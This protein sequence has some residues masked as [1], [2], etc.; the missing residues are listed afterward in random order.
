VYLT[1]KW[2]RFLQ[3][4]ERQCHSFADCLFVDQQL[5]FTKYAVVASCCQREKCKT[6]LF[7]ISFGW[8]GVSSMIR[9]HGQNFSAIQL[10]LSLCVLNCFHTV[11]SETVG[12]NGDRDFARRALS[13][14]AYVHSFGSDTRLQLE[15]LL[16]W[17]LPGM[18]HL[19]SL[20]M[21]LELNAL[22]R[23][24][25]RSMAV[26]VS[27]YIMC[28]GTHFY[29]RSSS[30]HS[31]LFNVR[32]LNSYCHVTS[33]TLLDELLRSTHLMY[34]WSAVSMLPMR[35]F[36]H[37]VIY[38]SNNKLLRISV[39]KLGFYHVWPLGRCHVAQTIRALS[40]FL[41]EFALQGNLH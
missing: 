23:S 6:R 24:H 19:D 17:K 31:S 33:C 11:L 7:W 8:S 35:Q 29:L 38:I 12:T 39:C 15:T 27:K 20:S 34:R 1:R 40:D 4:A 3:V 25:P 16:A 26:L 32:A 41:L 21:P 13:D 18:I 14:Y 2:Y 37:V 10:V 22:A 28:Y 30:S 36:S 9:C 5:S